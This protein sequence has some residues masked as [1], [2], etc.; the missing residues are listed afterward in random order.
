MSVDLDEEKGLGSSSSSV[1]QYDFDDELYKV[2]MTRLAQDLGITDREELGGGLSGA[3]TSSIRLEG[4]GA[5]HKKGQYILKV[6][7]SEKTEREIQMHK[8][9]KASGILRRYVPEYI[10]S[11]SYPNLPLTGIIPFP[12]GSNRS[13][14]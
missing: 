14:G 7:L 10:T 12:L 5:Y 8:T 4:N 6:G 1:N 13:V 2:F 3:R 9:A 11:K